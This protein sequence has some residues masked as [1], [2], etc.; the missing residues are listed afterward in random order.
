MSASGNSKKDELIA[1][2]EDM[3]DQIEY[4]QEKIEELTKQNSGAQETISQLSSD[5]S[6]LKN[7]LQKKSETVVS[8]NEQ[9][10]RMSEADLILKR[11][12]ELEMQNSE[13]NTFVHQIK[14]ETDEK[15]ER[16]FYVLVDFLSSHDDVLIEPSP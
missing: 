4:Q 9:I 6:K 5:N 11:N 13:M 16:G 1:M 8:L 10:G 15:L 12:S 3:Q 14:K 7:E 2:L